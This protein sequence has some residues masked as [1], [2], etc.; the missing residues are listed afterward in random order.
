MKHKHDVIC[1]S[2]C[3]AIE[4]MIGRNECSKQLYLAIIQL[5]SFSDED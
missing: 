1:I 5:C 4:D 2:V 3:L